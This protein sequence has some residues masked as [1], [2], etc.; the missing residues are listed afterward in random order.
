MS[1]I[2][3][4]RNMAL[5]PNLRISLVHRGTL[6]SRNDYAH[7]FAFIAC[8]PNVHCGLAA[9]PDF[10]PWFIEQLAKA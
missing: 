9:I 10:N 6:R 5:F 8:R 4:T 1:V 7:V 3:K 2:W